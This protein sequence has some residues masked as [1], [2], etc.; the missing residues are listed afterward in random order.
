[1]LKRLFRLL[2]LCLVAVLFLSAVLLTAARM[3]VPSLAEYRNDIV[4]A[5]T[6]ALDRPVTIRRLE[7]TWRGLSPVLKLR[8]VTIGSAQESQQQL[9][10]SE[11]WIRVD[12]RHYLA[13]REVRLSG[14]DVIGVD[15]TLARDAQGRVYIEELAGGGDAG[16][17]AGDFA[18]LSRLS[19]H[20]ASVTIRDLPGFREPQRIRDISLS[21]VNR[22]SRHEVSGYALLPGSL[23]ERVEIE[24]Q[25][26]GTTP[27]PLDWQGV[28]YFR[29]KA[30][31]MSSLFQGVLAETQAVEGSADVRLWA[32]RKRGRL[33][34]LRGEIEVAGF[35]LRQGEGKAATRF[36]ADRLQSQFGWQHEGE[37]WQLALQD[38][39][40]WQGANGWKA[41]NLSLAVVMRQQAHHVNASA[42][43]LDLEVLA[44]LLKV[45]PIDES[46]RAQL[47]TLQPTGLL[48]DLSVSLRHDAGATTLDHFDAHFIKLGVAQSGAIPMLSGLDGAISGSAGDGTLTLDSHV[49]ELH[50]TRLFRE[51][52]HFD[53]LQ[54]DLQWRDTG[55]GIELAGRAL[56]IGNKHLALEGD[57]VMTLPR[58]G[59]APSMDLQLAVRRA[60]VARFSDYLPAKVMSPTGVAWLDRSLVGGMVHDGTVV[61]QGRLD[62]I[63]FDHGEGRLEVRLPVTGATL[64]FNRHWSPVK[65]LDA[66]VDFTGRQMDIRSRAG[67]IRS[68]ALHNV[69]AQIRDLAKVRLT[70]KGDVHGALPV[71]L[72][73]LGSSP[74]GETYGGFVDRNTTTGNANLSLDILVPL[75]RDP[76]PVT[77]A[78]RIGLNGNTLRVRDSD[79][80]L[81]Q[82]H[83]RLDFDSEGIRGD[84]L[85]AT[86]FDRTAQVKVWTESGDSVTHIDLHGKLALFDQVLA[87]DHPLRQAVRDDSDWQVGLTVRGKPTRGKPAD[88]ALSVQST[89]VGAAIDLPAPLG[90][91]R[92]AVRELSIRVDNLEQRERQLQFSYAD[93]LQ[94]LLVIEQQQ[95]ARLLRGVLAFAGAEPVLPDNR[96]L[97]ITGQL[98]TFRL[99]DWQP[100]FGDEGD[101]PGLPLRMSVGI[102]EL[103]LL[104][105]RLRDAKLDIEVAG[106]VWTIKGLG[107][108]AEGEVRLTQS[109]DGLDTVVMNLQRLELERVADAG[110]QQEQQPLSPT[111]MPDLQVTAQ[112]LVYNG[113]NYGSLDLRAQKQPGGILEISRLAMSSDMLA[114]RLTGDW[115]V[116]GDISQTRVDLTVSD[117][118]M[119]WLLNAFGYQ[120]V[121]KG[122]EL[123]GN[124]QASWPGAPWSFARD[125]IDGKVRVV[126]KNGQILDVEPGA[127]GRAL[128]LLSL[129]KLPKRLTLDFSD[130]FGE[131][132]G[133]DRIAGNF[134]LDS[135]NA[136]T[137]DLEVDGP[138]AKIDI[139]GRVGLVAQDYDE[140]VT[141]TPYLQSSLPLAGA[142][143]G[144]PVV[145][146]AVIV[147]G[148]LLEKKLG[149][150]KMARKQ[151][152][153]T[154]PWAEPVVTRLASQEKDAGQDEDTTYLD[155]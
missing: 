13:E 95:P 70:I 6:A 144:G 149:L 131:G 27:N 5:A 92:D 87:E 56:S 102:G 21:L 106:R 66:Q 113:V 29:G 55:E 84:E 120:K 39:Q 26:R 63:P 20:D 35:S 112:Q 109:A 105:H 17:A 42:S 57:L 146:A 8:D 71:M 23:G 64:N 151:Y 19:I 93:I 127:A 152:T 136:Y 30:L 51:A 96:S 2:W 134:V 65:Q 32:E 11:V 91:P 24:A 49:V 25:L 115:R 135:G 43:R 128:G 78:G 76:D 14:V 50:D 88:V 132:F 22:G 85:R 129:D 67:M 154:G 77:V 53:R 41:D 16:S 62:Q 140:L 52:L 125:S 7:A 54:G 1:M 153:V 80:E 108:G 72:A 141:V 82:I 75:G 68:A 101:D 147:A 122:G 9:D 97:L 145:G 45:L 46:Y 58:D 114:L 44:G 107:P 4:M 60:D 117:G 61:I 90:K 118:R 104:G 98:E 38:L 86:L 123:S 124:L 126:I 121:M 10:I 36:D 143:A 48:Q 148:K 142:I 100:Y 18:T 139:S 28:I 83:G 59:G 69:H 99:A 3:W 110:A 15:L 94:G 37:A 31:A 119:D 111:D 103:E 150:N 137:N 138:A 130:L 79:I 89:L 12:V 133:F 116:Q 155:D 33:A 40:V 74:L 34:S 73:E 81:R 47:Q